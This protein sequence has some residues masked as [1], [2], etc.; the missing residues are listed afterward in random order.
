MTKFCIQAKETGEIKVFK[1]SENFLRDFICVDD[2]VKIKLS[3]MDKS[4]SGIV[5]LG[6]GSTKSFL[7]VAEAVAEK[8]SSKITEIEFPPHLLTQY[9]K[10]TCADTGKLKEL[11]GDYKFKTV[12]AFLLEQ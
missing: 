3:V 11:I 6:T 12:E 2:I 4:F 7:E 10:Y 5:N 1:G 8:Y 9:Q